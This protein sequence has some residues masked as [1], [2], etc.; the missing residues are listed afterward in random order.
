MALNVQQEIQ[1]D[2]EVVSQQ[3]FPF[4]PNAGT[5]YNNAG[6]IQINIENLTKS[7]LVTELLLISL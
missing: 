1:D 3:P 6:I 2:T 4:N 5:H 7:K